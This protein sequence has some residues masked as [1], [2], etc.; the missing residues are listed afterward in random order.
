MANLKD[1]FE[2]GLI[3][4]GDMGKVYANHFTKSNWK[5]NVCDLPANTETLKQYYKSNPLITVMDDGFGVSRRSD[6]I[7][8][9]VEAALIERVVAKYGP[10]TKVDAI[11]CGQVRTILYIFL[12]VDSELVDICERTRN[13]S[14]RSTY[15]KGLPYNH[16][17]FLARSKCQPRRIAISID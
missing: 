11:V 16:M 17:P 5:V 9:S 2:I 3:G 1:K 12:Y 8:Y 14:L 4:C 15:P 10:A 13:Q 7:I 6:F